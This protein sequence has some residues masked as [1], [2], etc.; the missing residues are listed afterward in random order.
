MIQPNN[1]ATKIQSRDGGV[2]AFIGGAAFREIC[3]ELG[4]R[5]DRNG[6]RD[7]QAVLPAILARTG[8]LDGLKCPVEGRDR[9]ESTGERDLGDRAVVV[10]EQSC[11]GLDAALQK[12]RLRIASREIGEL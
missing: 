11:S 4:Q 1:T 7:S 8:V 2:D 12:A 3:H 9:V 5:G 10:V 6:G